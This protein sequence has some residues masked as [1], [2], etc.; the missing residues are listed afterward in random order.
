MQYAK[1]R[2]LFKRIKKWFMRA[3]PAAL[4]LAVSAVVG[5]AS[6]TWLPGR[7]AA[8]AAVSA[9]VPYFRGSWVFLYLVLGATLYAL[10]C[11]RGAGAKTLLALYGALTFL[12]FFLPVLLLRGRGLDSFLYILM[13]LVMWFAAA[14]MMSKENKLLVAAQA[15]GML[16][17]VFMGYLS[18]YY[19]LMV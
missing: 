18:L 8:G 1:Y 17:L 3:Y 12:L 15:P 5:T 14:C 16:L 13:L 2:P 19:Y 4:C 6:G 10:F 7:A 11:R 9:A